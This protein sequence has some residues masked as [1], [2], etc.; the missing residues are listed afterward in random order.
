MDRR[1]Q[2]VYDFGVVLLE[3][4]TG[5]A[6]GRN[7]WSPEYGSRI[8]WIITRVL[9]R[10]NLVT[11]MDSNMGSYPLDDAFQ[12]TQLAVGCLGQDPLQ[13]PTMPQVEETLRQIKAAE[14]SLSLTTESDNSMSSDQRE[15]LMQERV[16]SS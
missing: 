6:L 2:D 12:V 7:R 1:R 3:I 15:G 4:L 10:D 11:L 5:L 8:E 16:S 9:D 14:I 13:R